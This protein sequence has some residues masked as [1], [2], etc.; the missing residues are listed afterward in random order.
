MRHGS[1]AIE[2]RMDA[3]VPN[4]RDSRLAIAVR[5]YDRNAARDGWVIAEVCPGGRDC[6]IVGSAVELLEACYPRTDNAF[7]S[8]EPIM[9]VAL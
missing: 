1:V 7:P 3:A 5:V 9:T 4:P 2:P 8:A 6:P